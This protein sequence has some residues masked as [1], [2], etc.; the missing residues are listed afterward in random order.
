MARPKGRALEQ[1]RAKRAEAVAA[2]KRASSRR[3]GFVIAGIA[4]GVLAVAAAIVLLQPPSPGVA[5]P[6]LG[7]NH[8]ASIDAAHAPY[9]SSPPSSGPHVGNLASW[10]E[11]TD[12]LPAEL[13]VH[14]LE[15][16]GVLLTYSCADCADLVEG[17][18]AAVGNFDGRHVVLFPYDDIVDGS[19][20]PYRAAAVAWGRVFYFDVVDEQTR[21]ELERFIKAYEGIDHHVRVPTP[22]G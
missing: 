11:Y 12:T 5:I 4:V 22:H 7:N 2:K 16:G 8:I 19:G 20:T 10:G 17:M 18:R 15:D 6:S 9:N 14:N 3:K 13:F 21:P 1:Q